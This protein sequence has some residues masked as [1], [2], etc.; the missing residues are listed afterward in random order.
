MKSIEKL[1]LLLLVIAG[2]VI[3]STGEGRALDNGLAKT[4]P[5]GWNSWN[6]FACNVSE[7]LIKEA[8][9]AMVISGMKEAGYQYVVIDDCW[10][11][12]RDDQGNIIADPARFP[13]GM[14]ALSDYVHSK[15]LKFGLYSDAG[16]LTC[17]KRPGGRGYEFQDAR[18]YAAW[19]VDYLKY[20]WCSHGTQ[21]SEDSYSI[22]R[23]ALAKSGRPI[24][25]SIC[26]WGSTKPWL[27]AGQVGNLWRTSGDIQD[28]WDCKRDWGGMGMI[29]VLDLQVGLETYAGPGHWNDPDMLEVGNGGMTDVEYRTHFSLWCLLAAPLMAG[30]DIR[31]MPASIAEILMN[32]EVIAIDQDPLGMQGTRVKKDGELEIWAKQLADGSRAVVLLN[33]GGSEKEM[34]VWWHDIGY[35]DKLSAS[36][37]DLWSKKELGRIKGNFAAKVASHGVVMIRVDPS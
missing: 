25:F 34:P 11:I 21:N 26:E 7:K 20:D 22:M 28:C 12:G 5:M 27:W 24:V 4:P 8:T 16:T 33:R 23:D 29:R 1:S 13:S 10:Q 30:N 35:P 15:G 32:K 14:K 17:Q 9:D 18:Q 19:G 3:F 6:K 2:F 31:S 36:V 37:R